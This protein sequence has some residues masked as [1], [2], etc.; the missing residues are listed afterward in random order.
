MASGGGNVP[1]A[2]NPRHS[3]DSGE[4]GEGAERISWSTGL[5]EEREHTQLFGREMKNQLVYK[6]KS[7]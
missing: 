3:L 6:E 5:D 7:F 1:A 4:N 2:G